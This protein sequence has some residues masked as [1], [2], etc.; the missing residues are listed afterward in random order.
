MP[1]AQCP[2]DPG[3]LL[4]CWKKTGSLYGDSHSQGGMT[5]GA[6]VCA[7]GTWDSDQNYALWQET[8]LEPFWSVTLKKL[9]EEEISKCWRRNQVVR[10]H[11][12]ATKLVRMSDKFCINWRLECHELIYRPTWTVSHVLCT[13]TPKDSIRLRCWHSRTFFL[14]RDYIFLILICIADTQIHNL[15][16][17]NR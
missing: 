6:R 3:T 12:L 5:S 10:M 4:R 16:H 17:I 7:E 14:Q 9:R 11:A 15:N 2:T 1:L 13:V 8:R